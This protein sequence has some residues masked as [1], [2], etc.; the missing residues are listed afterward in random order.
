MKY[1]SAIDLSRALVL[2][3]LSILFKILQEAL[4]ITA[5]QKPFVIFMNLFGWFKIHGNR[6]PGI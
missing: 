1:H 5:K 2:V 4:Q 3:I 6:I